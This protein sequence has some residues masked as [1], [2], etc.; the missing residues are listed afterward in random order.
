[1]HAEGSLWR[2]SGL[3][4]VSNGR[5]VHLIPGRLIWHVQFWD[6]FFGKLTVTLEHEAAEE[7][8][9]V[10]LGTD[11]VRVAAGRIRLPAAVLAAA[12]AP[13]NT[14][15]PGGRLNLQ[16]DNL[17]FEQGR[18]EGNAQLD[19]EEAQSALS[20]VA[21]LGSF[22]LTATGRGELGQANLV[23]LKGPLLL[24]GEGSMD[25]AGIRFRGT[26]EADPEMR[27]SL[28][29]LIGLL[30][31]RNAGRVVLDWEIRN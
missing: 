14:I 23:T 24:Q 11:A 22:R 12:G 21:P 30:G 28:D 26:A 17:R 31:Q 19:W 29:G 13:F 9:E 4:A 18:F 8:I 2:G 5:Q 3:L 10:T 6:L 1:V 16:W 27:D 7:A 15:R 25:G 20:S